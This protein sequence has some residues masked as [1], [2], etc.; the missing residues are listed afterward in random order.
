MFTERQLFAINSFLKTLKAS[1]N[2]VFENTFYQLKIASVSLITITLAPAMY[3]PVVAQTGSPNLPTLDAQSPEQAE[4][5]EMM[6]ETPTEAASEDAFSDV[7]SSGSL[8]D[9]SEES[10]RLGAGDVLQVSVF[11]AEDYSGEFTVLPGGVLNLPLVGDVSVKGLTLREASG[12]IQQQLSQYVR[13]PRVTLSMLATRPVQVAIAGQVNRPGA[14]SLSLDE[15]ENPTLTQV[16]EQAGGI[17]Q[18]A[19]I[20]QITVERQQGRREPVQLSVD[21]WQLLQEG[22]ID[23]DLALQDGDR[24]VVPTATAL[25]PEEANAM[26]TASF[27]PDQITVNVVGEVAQPGAIEVP[28]NTPLNQAI[29]AAGGFNNRASQGTVSLVRLNVNGTVTQQEIAVDFASGISDEQ[30]P[31]LRPYDTVIVDR[32]GLTRTT[33]TLGSVLSPLSGLFNLFRLLGG[34]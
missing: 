34:F 12:V 9:F 22:R 24:I 30:N 13:R 29:L 5:P 16:I 20:R 14:Y 25:P 28:P 19:D 2:M 21:L 3:T 23:T 15:G 8:E 4:I 31:P 17:T 10:Y 7:F 6:P 18:S 32:N 26:A 1:R 33:D 27:S 11:N